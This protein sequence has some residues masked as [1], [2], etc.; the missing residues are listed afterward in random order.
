[1]SRQWIEPILDRSDADI[2]NRTAKA[3]L[4][5]GDIRRIESNIAYLSEQLR[6]H[7]Y[8]FEA[9][10]PG[11]WSKDDIAKVADLERVRDSIIAIMQTY[12]ELEAHTVTLQA[13]MFERLDFTNVNDIEHVLF[14]VHTLLTN[15]DR[16]K[17]L[18]WAM[19][20]AHAGLYVGC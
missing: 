16:S 18:G 1:M 4:N 10:I 12:H 20:M 2:V 11:N 7:G 19:G 13:M 15:S 5:V 6:I 17:S 9:I 8:S 14:D 3:F